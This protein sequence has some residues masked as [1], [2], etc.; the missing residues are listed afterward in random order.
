LNHTTNVHHAKFDDSS[1]FFSSFFFW[2]GKVS[3][4]QQKYIKYTMSIYITLGY[5]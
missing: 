1:F 4:A 3:R 2:A 5:Q